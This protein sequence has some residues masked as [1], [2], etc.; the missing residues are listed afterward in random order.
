MM[1]LI[2]FS[3][4]VVVKVTVN[5]VFFLNLLVSPYLSFPPRPLRAS[6]FKSPRLMEGS[7]TNARFCAG[8]PHNAGHCSVI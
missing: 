8:K 2:T 1:G 6:A 7:D 3:Y 4:I 5:R